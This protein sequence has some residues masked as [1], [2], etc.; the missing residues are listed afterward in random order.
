M[1][2]GV[3]QK[4]KPESGSWKWLEVAGKYLEIKYVRIQCFSNALS[5]GDLVRVATEAGVTNC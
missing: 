3:E 1:W 5:E 4:E 2:R